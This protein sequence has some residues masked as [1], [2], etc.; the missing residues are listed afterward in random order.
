VEIAPDAGYVIGVD[1]RETHPVRIAVRDAHGR[2]LIKDPA[3]LDLPSGTPVGEDDVWSAEPAVTMPGASELLELATTGIEICTRDLDKNDLLGIGISLPGPVKDG[4]VV[5]PNANPWDLVRADESLVRILGDKLPDVGPT[6]AERTEK[7]VVTRSD[8][9]ASAVTEYL[10]GAREAA[11]P[12]C[13]VVKWSFDLC[14]ALILDGEL[15]TGSGG[16]A[17]AIGHLVVDEDESGAMCDVCGRRQCLHAVADLRRLSQIATGQV[18]A[19]PSAEAIKV[20]FDRGDPDI[21]K[22]LKLAAKWI[23][24]A[25][26][27]YVAALDPATV[28]LGGAIGG[29][30]F[31][32]VQVDFMEQITNCLP[33]REMG[34]LTV[35]GATRTRNTATLGAAACALLQLGP[36]RLKSFATETKT[37]GGQA[38]RKGRNG[39]L[40][41]SGNGAAL[42]VPGVS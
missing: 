33:G 36:E 2:N 28:I 22:Q 26:S 9:Y 10:W 14:A 29:R 32:G 24:T 30:V 12:E 35:A 7:L 3:I 18:E 11:T 37:K 41:H 38:T 19:M 15:Y 42:A 8:A 31:D 16:R 1:L 4:F 27:S 23:G 25:V 6:V 20:A 5:G 34:D 21:T 39:D 40:G 17:G 13:V